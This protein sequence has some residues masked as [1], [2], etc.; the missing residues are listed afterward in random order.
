MELALTPNEF[1]AVLRELRDEFRAARAEDQT[2]AREWRVEIREDM[3]EVKAGLADVNGHLRKLNGKVAEQQL[4]IALLE[5]EDSDRDRH[6]E[7]GARTTDKWLFFLRELTK[8]IWFWITV[9]ILIACVQW[10]GFF[11]EA[12]KRWLTKQGY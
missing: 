12:G 5:K 2:Q 3:K 6:Q 4:Q 1:T 11:A 9:L 8:N 7:F 10:G